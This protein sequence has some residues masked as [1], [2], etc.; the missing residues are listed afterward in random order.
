MKQLSEKDTQRL[1]TLYQ[2]G[3]YQSAVIESKKLI[4]NHPGELILHNILG[5]CLERQGLFQP[6]ANAYQDALKINP[7]VPELQFNMGAMLY[8]LNRWDDQ[9]KFYR[10]FF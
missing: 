3:N 2:Q 6:A 8:A 7:A 10:S 9:P 1:M 5:V 4:N